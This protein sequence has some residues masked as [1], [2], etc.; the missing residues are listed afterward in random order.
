MIRV[1]CTRT[2]CC[3][4]IYV[5]GAWCCCVLRAARSKSWLKSQ[6]ILL[7][8][9]IHIY[10]YIP[11]YTRI[12][13]IP[14]CHIQVCGYHSPPGQS[15]IGHV[16]CHVVCRLATGDERWRSF[17]FCLHF[18]VIYTTRART[19]QQ[20]ESLLYHLSSGG[21]WVSFFIFLAIL[22]LY[23]IYSTAKHPPPITITTTKL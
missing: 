23:V 2:V 10:M 11:V 1:Q 9:H 19:P 7:H 3:G 20:S 18:A 8:I 12:Y 5:L 13:T 16:Q 22:R 14:I 15:I 6:H 21:M 17:F 4:P